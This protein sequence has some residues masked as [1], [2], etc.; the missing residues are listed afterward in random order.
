MRYDFFLQL[1]ASFYIVGYLPKPIIQN[2]AKTYIVK[3]KN[4]AYL[5]HFLLFKS[6]LWA[7]ADFSGQKICKKSTL[8]D[9]L[10]DDHYMNWMNLIII[11]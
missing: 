11:L 8:K 5:C 7:K 6:I 2:L 9:P 4:L 1:N 10:K 3:I